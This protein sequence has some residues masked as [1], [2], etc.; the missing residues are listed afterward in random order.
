MTEPLRVRLSHER[1]ATALAQ[2]LRDL[3]RFKVER[4]DAIWEITIAGTLGDRA[5]VRVLNAVR[6]ALDGESTATALVLMNGSE[7]VLQGE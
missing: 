4:R 7:Y 5:V 6:L 1:H 2:E 3:A